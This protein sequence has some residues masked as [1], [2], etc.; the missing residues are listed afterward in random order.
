MQSEF[1]S[2][3]FDPK[4]WK[5]GTPVAAKYSVRIFKGRDNSLQAYQ[6]NLCEIYTKWVLFMTDMLC[7]VFVH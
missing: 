2:G 5:K 4:Q 7:S 1:R 3:P 6:N